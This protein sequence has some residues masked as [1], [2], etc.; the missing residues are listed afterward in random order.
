MKAF[1]LVIP[2][3][4]MEQAIE[5]HTRGDWEA[6]NSQIRAALEGLF[7][8]IARKIDPSRA[9]ALQPGINCRQM[10]ADPAIGF[11]AVERKEWTVDGENFLEGMFKMLHTDGAHP[12]LSNED[13]STFR[14]HLFLV[15]ARTFL[16]RFEQGRPA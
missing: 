5:A 13:H 2:L 12:G 4:H 1:G 16:R 10:L 7:N 14:L 15:T 8:D 11:L 6:A 3:N 9:G